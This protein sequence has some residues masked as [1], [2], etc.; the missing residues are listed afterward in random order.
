MPIVTERHERADDAG[1]PQGWTPAVR[2]DRGG[3]LERAERTPSGGVR[4]PGAVVCAGVLTYQRVDGTTVRELVPPDE[5]GNPESLRT[6]RD[7]PVTV[8]HP[9]PDAEG[10]QRVT[11]E[12]HREL[13]VG[14]VSGEPRFEDEHAIAELVVLEA[15]AIAR[16]DAGELTELSP[17]YKCFID[18]TPGV[19]RGQPYDQVQRERTYNHVALL[20][21]GGAR[22]GASVAL[23]VDG[24][25][26]DYAVQIDRPTTERAD[27]MEH[28][29]I[30]GITYKVGSPEWREALSRKVARL[31]EEMAKLE[32][33]KKDAEAEVEKKDADLEAMKAERDAH[34]AKVAELEAKI[35]ELENPEAVDARADARAALLGTARQVLGADAKLARA[36][37]KPMSD[38]EIRIAILAKLAPDVDA[39]KVAPAYLDARFDSE[40]AML[41]R[42]PSSPLATARADAF[43]PPPAGNGATGNPHTFGR[44]P[45]RAL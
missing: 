19:W 22:G 18:A 16:V 31:D 42:S 8:G 36:D 30:D 9:A 41:R 29:R 45:P 23:R 39:T 7:A 35:A 17:G 20:P 33:E 34:A 27:S 40:L 5:V 25:A 10:S 14:H 12:T 32:G 21:S 11:P 28:E 13:S 4:V 15:S 37:G 2:S 3:R 6:L 26:G 1:H 38:R 24:V 43:T 44:T